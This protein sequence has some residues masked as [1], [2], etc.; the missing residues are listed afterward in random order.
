MENNTYEFL[1][2][3]K[4]FNRVTH[5]SDIIHVYHDAT[6]SHYEFYSI[7]GMY[8]WTSQPAIKISHYEMTKYYYHEVNYDFYKIIKCEVTR[9]KREKL[10]EN[11][12]D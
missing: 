9:K 10:L 1:M 5:C 7:R 12:L 4:L 11:L 2:E 3:I 6:F 8:E